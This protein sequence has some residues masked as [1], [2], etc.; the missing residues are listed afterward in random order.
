MLHFFDTLYVQFAKT[1]QFPLE[2]YL[3]APKD[4][5]NIWAFFHPTPSPLPTAF[6]EYMVTALL[7]LWSL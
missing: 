5:R 2:A 7:E 1:Q 4:D 6:R 3:R